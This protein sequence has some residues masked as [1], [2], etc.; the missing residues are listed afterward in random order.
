MYLNPDLQGDL[1]LVTN[2]TTKVVSVADVKSH[3]RIDTSDEDTLLGLY[4]DAATE[5]AENFCGRHFI[6]HEYRLYF[7]SV[8]SV[9]SLVYPD[10]TLDVINPV[11]WID[12]DSDSQ[13]AS[14]KA[15]IDAYSC[16]L[17]TSP[18]PRDRTR[19]RMPSSA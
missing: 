11:K 18:S 16:L 3:L 9:A 12:N 1:V 7:D 8:T 14:T 6:K 13:F 5:M 19:S 10:C 2:P 15:H 17:Y 4:I